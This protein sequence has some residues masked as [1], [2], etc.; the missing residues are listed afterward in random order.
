MKENKKTLG[1][2]L[3]CILCVCNQSS[4]YVMFVDPYIVVQFLHWKT[5]QDA[6]D[7]GRCV[8]SNMLYF[9]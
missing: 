2:N 1:L 7:G 5:Q 4:N 3:E 6:P 8:A 9:I